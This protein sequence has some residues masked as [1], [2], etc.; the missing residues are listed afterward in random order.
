MPH[1][2]A[3]AGPKPVRGCPPCIQ[4]PLTRGD[5]LPPLQELRRQHSRVV[6][7]DH[8]QR[9]TKH[10]ALRD[11]QVDTSIRV[12]DPAPCGCSGRGSE[13][14]GGARLERDRSHPVH[15]SVKHRFAPRNAAAAGQLARQ[16]RAR[17]Q[18]RRSWKSLRQGN[19]GER[20]GPGSSRTA[21]GLPEVGGPQQGGSGPVGLQGNSAHAARMSSRSDAPGRNAQRCS[22]PC[23]Q[24]QHDTE[25]CARS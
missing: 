6:C 20:A 22:A 12:L 14:Q 25:R 17:R 24:R 23:R 13:L 1:A 10:S 18:V 19:G 9:R 2:K 4:A 16:A 7:T 8:P 15:P 21:L 5:P 3:G 11:T